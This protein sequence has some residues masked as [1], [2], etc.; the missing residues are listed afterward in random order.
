MYALLGSEQAPR[1]DAASV[2]PHQLSCASS[3][4]ADRLEV[5]R[6]GRAKRAGLPQLGRKHGHNDGVSGITRGPHHNME[7]MH[8]TT[9]VWDRPF[10]LVMVPASMVVR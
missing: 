2:G 7:L 6:F 9:Y 1:R 4:G 3:V 5:G 10:R 8:G